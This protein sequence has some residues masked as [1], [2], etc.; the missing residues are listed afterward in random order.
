M[1]R[2][3]LPVDQCH[4]ATLFLVGREAHH[5]LRVLRLRRGDRVTVLNGVGGELLCEV[6]QFDRD[7][8]KLSVV[9]KRAIPPL[10][11][12]ITLLQALPKGKII[13]SII[14]KATELGAF[15]VVPLLSERVAAAPSG[16]KPAVDKTEKWRLVAVEAIKQCGSG[17]L[18]QI[19]PPVTPEQFLARNETFDLPLIASLQGGSRHPREYFAAYRAER[20]KTPQ[21]VCVWIG[22]EGDFSTKEVAMITAAGA[23]PMTLGRLV[24][25][26]ETAATYCLS[27]FNYELQAPR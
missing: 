13:E 19:E 23:L 12:E 11:Y 9:E 25:R 2:F 26:T 18:P 5:A 1:P 4:D 14:Q 20:G 6:E 27:I 3:Y 22:P 17:W 8:V 21:S 10:P 7:K 24:L 16:K 15:R